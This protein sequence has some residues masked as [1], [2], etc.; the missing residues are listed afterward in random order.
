MKNIIFLFLVFSNSILAQVNLVPNSSFEEFINCPKN[1]GSINNYLENTTFLKNWYNPTA[2][3]LLLASPDYFNTCSFDLNS[4]VGIPLNFAGTQIPHSGLAYIG[5]NVNNI[6]RSSEN[7]ECELSSKLKKN[8]I[9]KVKMYVN[10]ADAR[11]SDSSS[12]WPGYWNTASTNKHLQISFSDSLVYWENSNNFNVVLSNAICLDTVKFYSDTVKWESVS[13]FYK[14]KGNEQYLILGDINNN[15]T[16]PRLFIYKISGNITSGFENSWLSYYYIDDVSVI[17]VTHFI[18]GD[19]Q[20]CKGANATL[21]TLVDFDKYTWN[22][23]D[24][25]QQITINKSGWYWCLVTEGCDTHIDSFFVAQSLDSVDVMPVSLGVD[26]LNC[27]SDIEYW[28]QKIGLQTPKNTTDKI[29]WN[30]S[31][32]DNDLTDIMVNQAGNYWVTVYNQCFAKSDTLIITGCPQKTPTIFAP[33]AFTPNDDG[34]NDVFS[35]NT[36]Y[37]NIK[38]LKIFD[39]WGSLIHEDK[40]YFNWA[41]YSKGKLCDNGTYYYAIEYTDWN[42]SKVKVYTGDVVLVR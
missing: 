35:L 41:G 1:F 5:Y 40:V 37:V 8:S 10:L 36:K 11:S 16:N 27:F 32:S 25:S 34:I 38:S 42:D 9:Y 12:N 20:I 39:R 3:S 22:T 26:I 33:N 24:T 23:G 21:K 30:T 28:P 13:G 2:I 31:V 18:T 7:I 6:N 19:S 14:S 15:D 29:K 17:D 4:L